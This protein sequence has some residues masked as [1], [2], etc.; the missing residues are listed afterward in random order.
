MA[1]CASMILSN[2]FTPYFSP[3]VSGRV[4]TLGIQVREAGVIEHNVEPDAQE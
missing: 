4:A 2:S 1:V 3:I